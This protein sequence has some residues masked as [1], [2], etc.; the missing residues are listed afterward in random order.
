MGLE[1]NLEVLLIKQECLTASSTV[2]F[3]AGGLPKLTSCGVA[4]I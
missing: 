1:Q 3:A 2:C 4:T